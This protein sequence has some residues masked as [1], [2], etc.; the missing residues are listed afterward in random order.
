MEA[1]Q[2]FL[3]NNFEWV[4][5]KE[6]SEKCV[7]VTLKLVGATGTGDPN[8]PP[9]L[10]GSPTLKEVRLPKSQI[11]FSSFCGKDLITIP[12]WLAVR[13]GLVSDVSSVTPPIKATGISHPSKDSGPVCLNKP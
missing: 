6:V 5:R 9:D 3:K 13:V 7:S 8:A 10:R 2:A 11:Q 12:E 1:W 4:S